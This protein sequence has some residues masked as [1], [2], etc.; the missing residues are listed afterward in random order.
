MSAQVVRAPELNNSVA[1]LFHGSYELHKIIQQTG[2]ETVTI[3]TSGGQES[4]FDLP[5]DVFNLG[6]S[7]LEFTATY[8]ASGAGEYD[9]VYAD[10]VSVMRQLQLYT[11]SGLMLCDIPHLSKYLKAVGRWEMSADELATQ[12]IAVSPSGATA[13]GLK[14][15]L[16][17]SNSTA[18]TNYRPVTVAAGSRAYLEPQYLIRGTTANSA[19]PV[20]KYS[21]PLKHIFQTIFSLDRDLYFGGEIVQMRIVWAPSTEAYFFSDSATDPTANVTVAAGS[22]ALSGLRLYLAIEKDLRIQTEV[23]NAVMGGGM[24]VSVPYVSESR[25]SLSSTSQTPILRL[26]RANGQVCQKIY[27]SVFS[28]TESINTAFDNNNIGDAKVSDFYITVNGVRTTQFNIDTSAYDD[29]L[30][31]RDALK[32]SSYFGTEDFG[33]NWCFPLNFKD[34]MNWLT[35]PP[36]SILPM[37]NVPVGL[38]L[39]QEVQ[40]Q[41]IATTANATLLHY[42]YSIC[43][44]DLM[45]SSAGISFY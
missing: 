2:G 28:N 8:P 19:H 21:I 37:A 38:D 40:V 35:V 16:Q 6:R 12:T 27:W 24:K 26:N 25:Q 30:A 4:I 45:V 36:E 44:K 3:T 1:D 23:K 42:I 29:V 11:R 17:P 41:F 13:D 39:S 43:T 9:W 7:V 22:V 20:I 31:L 14:G 5:P 10:T 18:A 32:G 33:Y 15:V 34:S